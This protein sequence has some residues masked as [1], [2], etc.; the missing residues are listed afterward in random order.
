MVLRRRADHRGPADVD[1]LDGQLVGAV[2]AR[3]GGLE[4]V[5]VHHHEI[6]GLDVVLG[7]DL[8]VQITPA[9][10]AAVNLR[11]Q[12]LHP[13]VHHFRKTGVVGHL[14]HQDAGFRKHPVRTPR[15]QQLHAQGRKPAGEL[16]EPRFVRNTQ[17]GAGHTPRI[18]VAHMIP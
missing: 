15:G 8:D 6:D 14:L 7:H 2:G 13:A 9:E 10:D 12:R 5:E 11:V 4:R 1:V 16:L 17:Q 3:D 18:S